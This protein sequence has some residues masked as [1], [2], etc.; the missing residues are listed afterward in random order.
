MILIKDERRVQNFSALRGRNKSSWG[1]WDKWHSHLNPKNKIQKH[2]VRAA[3]SSARGH[4][5][6]ALKLINEK[7]FVSV[8]RPL[9]MDSSFVAVRRGVWS[10][11]VQGAV[12]LLYRRCQDS[13]A[14]SPRRGS[15]PMLHANEHSLLNGL[16][17]P[18]LSPHPL[19][20]S[21]TSPPPH[22]SLP[23]PCSP[24]SSF[25]HIREETCRVSAAS[26]H[27]GRVF[28]NR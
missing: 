14:H 2:L 8:E 1:V 6:S 19:L 25:W 28:I 3:F 11:D 4:L 24:L 16:F 27:R 13:T 26:A 5:R 17:A 9:K 20:T 18:V 7:S 12:C 21:L 10:R 23:S 15:G 22:T